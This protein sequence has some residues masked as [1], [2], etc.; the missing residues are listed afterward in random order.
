MSL[1]P[2]TTEKDY[3]RLRGLAGVDLAGVRA[4]PIRLA[5]QDEQGLRTL[6]CS[7]LAAA[8]AR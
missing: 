8:R 3:V 6:I 4:F 5:V 7:R 2:L 1:V